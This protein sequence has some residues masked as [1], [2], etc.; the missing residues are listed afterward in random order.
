MNVSLS[1]LPVGEW[2]DLTDD[3]LITLFEAIENQLLKHHRNQ[4][5]ISRKNKSVVMQKALG[6]HIPQTKPKNG[7]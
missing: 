2:R 4:S 6:I 1:G 3:E 7:K 5:K